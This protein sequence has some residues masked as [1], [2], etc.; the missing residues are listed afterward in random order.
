[1]S[2]GILS[3]VLFGALLHASWNVLVKRNTDKLLATAGVFLG[4]G[5]LSALL[6]PWLPLPA[7]AAWP[8]LIVS[9]AAEVLY[10]ALL[11]RAYHQ[12]DLSHAYP[13]MRG[14]PPLLVAACT[15]LLAHE[16]LS[17]WTFA[18]IALVC[19]G[20]LSL[21]FAPS[22][23]AATAPQAA[24]TRTA[25]LNACVIATYTL[26]DGLG[27]RVSGNPLA[28][29][30]WLFSFT[31]AAWL[32]WAVLWAGRQR[33]RQLLG[34]LP[35]TLAGGACSL[36]SYG[37]ALWAMTRAPIAA[38]AAVRE[39][40]IV[41]GVILGRLVLQERITPARAF[42]AVLVTLGVYLIRGHA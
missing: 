35:R 17:P 25:L 21:V 11:A 28:Y 41:F 2:V 3:A 27:V 10:A 16:H 1:M 15:V 19:L 39:T 5:V 37:I 31:G 14:T 34:D 29:I 42:A 22:G 6:I 12:G 40:S 33:Q 13:L 30:L 4:S 20:I 24:A 7:P 36:G 8:Y 32:V 9:T 23:G 18:G 38:V 26:I